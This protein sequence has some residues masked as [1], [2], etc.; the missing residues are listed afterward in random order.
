[1]SSCVLYKYVLILAL[2]QTFNDLCNGY[3]Q[4][5]PV[6]MH[7]F[8]SAKISQIL[9]KLF[10]SFMMNENVQT[11]L[12]GFK[13]H[14]NVTLSFLFLNHSH[15]SLIRIFSCSRI[16]SIHQIFSIVS[17]AFKRLTAPIIF[18]VQASHLS[19]L[20]CNEKSSMLTSFT[21]HHHKINGSSSFI[22][23]RFRYI[24]PSQV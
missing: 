6:R 13:L 3:A 2:H 1:M 23:S 18:G 24:I 12:S 11:R 17:N 8:F 10:S 7:I 4:C 22:N 16:F 14:N 20:F 9:L 19:A 15:K 5:H 21:V